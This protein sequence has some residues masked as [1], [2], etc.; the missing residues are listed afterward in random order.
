MIA[1]LLAIFLMKMGFSKTQIGIV[2]SV[3]LI[4]AAIGNLLL[5]S[6]AISLEEEKPSSSMHFSARRGLSRSAFAQL[7][8][9]H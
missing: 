7:L 3:G 1:V 6:L 8:P 2:V 9:Q 5:H 4:G